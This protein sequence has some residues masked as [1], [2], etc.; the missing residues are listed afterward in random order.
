VVDAYYAYDNALLDIA[1]N[2]ED[3]LGNYGRLA[4]KA[5]RVAILFANLENDGVIKMKHWART[6]GITERHR[7]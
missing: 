3:L 4:E 2:N 6:Q 5:L 1:E 7:F